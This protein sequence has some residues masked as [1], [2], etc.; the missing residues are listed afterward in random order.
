[1]AGG[2]LVDLN[3]GRCARS[4]ASHAPAFQKAM[5]ESPL[6]PASHRAQ[7]ARAQPCPQPSRR[8]ERERTQQ[9]LPD[10]EYPHRYGLHSYLAH[11]PIGS[12]PRAVRA[13][14]ALAT[15]SAWL[16]WA[17]WSIVEHSPSVFLMAPGEPSIVLSLQTRVL[18][19]DGFI[20]G[21]ALGG[22]R[23][24]AQ[25]EHEYKRRN[26]RSN[27]QDHR[28]GSAGGRNALRVVTRAILVELIGHL[29]ISLE[30]LFRSAMRVVQRALRVE[31][32]LRSRVLLSGV[33]RVGRARTASIT[34]SVLPLA[35][36]HRRPGRGILDHSKPRSYPRAIAPTS[37]A[38]QPR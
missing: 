15:S 21:P 5:S 2:S 4:N 3:Y 27:S 23:H 30:R 9:D 1:M 22:E 6:P 34:L 26:A 24:D 29:L 33:G 32:A 19:I 17:S 18:A 37:R 16:H 35:P 28:L 11:G 14:F 25:G 10:K 38:A 7:G 31:G 13:R 36:P 8:A 12:S 20:D